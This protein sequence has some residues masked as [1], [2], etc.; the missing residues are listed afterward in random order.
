MAPEVIKNFTAKA[1]VERLIG[2]AQ[3]AEMQ[4]DEVRQF[5]AQY[6]PPP[7]HESGY[8]VPTQEELM[9]QIKR[10][11]DAL[12]AFNKKITEHK[13]DLLASTWSY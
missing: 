2:A 7:P 5:A 11:E 3:Q 9:M 6:D 1:R 4:L 12:V 13:A 8:L 10:W